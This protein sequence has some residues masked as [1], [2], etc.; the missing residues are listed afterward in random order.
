[1]L[2]AGDPPGRTG[3]LARRT[4]RGEIALMLAVFGVTAALVSYA[5]PIDAASGPFSTNTTLGPIELEMTVEPAQSRAEHRPPVP[6]RRQGRDPVHG[7]EGTHGDREPAREGHWPAAAAPRPWRA[8]VTTS[9]TRPCSARAGHGRSRSPTGS[10]NSNSIRGPSGSRSA[11]TK[12]PRLALN[13]TLV[14]D[15]L[16]LLARHSAPRADAPQTERSGA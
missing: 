16:G 9:S 8:P 3:A 4:M 10:P 12:P 13:T 7:H 11:E 1:M 14:L 5:P 2:R 6:D 15:A